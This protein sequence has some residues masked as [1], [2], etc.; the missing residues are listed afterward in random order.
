MATMPVMTVSLSGDVPDRT[1]IYHA[2]K[3]QNEIERIPGILEATIV[4]DR[5][6]LLE[7]L[8]SPTKLDNYNVSLSG[9]I[10]SMS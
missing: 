10:Q 8:V 1:L 2:Q 9:L 3:L 6:E 5:E 4:G 7:I